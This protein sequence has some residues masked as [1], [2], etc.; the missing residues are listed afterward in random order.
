MVLLMA[1]LTACAAQTAGTTTA[2]PPQ[3]Q[4]PPSPEETLRVRATRYWDARVKGD[5]VTQYEYLEPR[6]REQVTLTGFVRARGG[7]V[8]QSYELEEVNVVGDEG[9]VAS[10]ATFRVTL[11]D[12]ERFG[13]WT[14]RV[15][16]HWVKVGDQWYVRYDQEGVKRLLEAGEGRSSAE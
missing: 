6:A 5:L 2:T 4:A 11:K 16:M 13:P 7:V 15:L 8:F 9:L 12:V 3:A 14:Q 10:R 1:L